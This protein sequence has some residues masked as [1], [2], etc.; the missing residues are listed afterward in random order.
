MAKI[1]NIK[2]HPK[3]KMHFAEKFNCKT[4]V[5]FEENSTH[6]FYYLIYT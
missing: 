1:N 4:P 6:L 2:K 3:F 5:C